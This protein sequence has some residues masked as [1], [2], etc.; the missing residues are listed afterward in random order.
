MRRKTHKISLLLAMSL[1]VLSGCKSKPL[2]PPTDYEIDTSI[3]NENGDVYYEIFVRSFADSDGDGIGDFLGLKAKIPYLATLGVKGLWLMPIHPS[4]SYHGYDVD[5]YKAIHSDFGTIND[6]DA[7]MSEAR[8]H[9]IDVIIDLV[10]NHSS[11]SHPWFLEGKENFTNG[12]VNP[13]DHANKANY[14]NFYRRDGQVEYEA[15]FGPWMP[16]LNLANPYVQEEIVDIMQFWFNHGVKGFRLDAVPH[17]FGSSIASTKLPE[18]KTSLQA[19]IDFMQWLKEK[20]TTMR[21]D[22]YFVAE[23]W[24]G[25]ETQVSPYYASTIDSFFNFAGGDVNGYMLEYIRTKKATQL[26]QKIANVHNLNRSVHPNAL[27]ANFLSNHDMDRSS[28]MWVMDMEAR[29]KLGASVLILQPGIPFM[30]YGEEIG[31]RGTRGGENTDANRRLPMIW[32]KTDDTM[33]TNNPVG[34]TFPSSSQVKDGVK[35]NLETPFSLLNHYR[36]VISI[37]NKYK[38]I[39]RAEIRDIRVSGTNDSITMLEMK[40]PNEG[41]KIYVVHNIEREEVSFDLGKLNL[42]TLKITDDIFTSEVRATLVDNTL[43]L[44]AYSSVVLAVK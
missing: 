18:G 19:N 35:E 26:A 13:L 44:A 42:G 6:F 28:R 9:N 21:E 1:L 5:N 30:Y 12:Y 8:A 27:T 23:A 33:R 14:Y 11:N 24:Y 22:N 15:A 38:F 3:T 2:P 10:L 39:T 17:F 25:V 29:Q 4:P 40:G 36:K 34:A 20:A 43:S 31:L 16:D 32:Q 7:M 41:E 37:R